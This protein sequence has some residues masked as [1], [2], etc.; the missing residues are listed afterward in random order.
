MNRLTLA[1]ML[2]L[3]SPALAGAAEPPAAEADPPLTPD[4]AKLFGRLKGA[5][6]ARVEARLAAAME[7]AA[8]VD[9]DGK[10]QGGGLGLVIYT[11]I[12]TIVAKLVQA[13]IWAAVLAYWLWLVAGVVVVAFPTGWLAG[14]FGSKKDG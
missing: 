14:R 10:R 6:D 11:A 2:G 3:A 5:I 7:Q 4:D 9:D 12:K 1:L 8:A 13:G